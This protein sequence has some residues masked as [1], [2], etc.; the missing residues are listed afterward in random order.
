[1]SLSYLVVPIV[2]INVTHAQ[3]AG[4]TTTAR[5]FVFLDFLAIHMKI[6]IQNQWQF[7]GH[8]LLKSF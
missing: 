7:S 1:M 8:I 5:S 2:V 4:F 6:I 3:A